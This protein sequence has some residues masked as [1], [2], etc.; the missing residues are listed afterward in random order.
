MPNA[1][2]DRGRAYLWSRRW[3]EAE[4]KTA[5]EIKAGRVNTFDSADDLIRDLDQE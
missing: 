3:Q 5:E 2:M 1:L 4:K